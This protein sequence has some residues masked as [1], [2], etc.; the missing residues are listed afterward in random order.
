MIIGVDFD[1]TIVCYDRLFQKVAVE[2]GLM[3]PGLPASKSSIRN[4]LRKT[5]REDLWTEMQGYV[6]GS[7]MAEAE[8]FPG[9]LDFFRDCR[10]AGLTLA[11]ISH[12]TRNPYLGANYD[13]HEAAL[14]WLTQQGFFDPDKLG[15]PR[16]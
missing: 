16:Q 4:H 15:L 7:R 5:G 2:R 10:L 3:P 11:I 1:N 12:K 14:Q 6:Y 8:A 13:L 9:V